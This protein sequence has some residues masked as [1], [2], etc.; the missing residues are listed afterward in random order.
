MSYPR[1]KRPRNLLA[2]MILN[3]LAGS[4]AGA[5]A[6][7]L[8]YV[9]AEIIRLGPLSDAGDRLMFFL[10]VI[11]IAL[12]Y[13][14]PVVLVLVFAGEYIARRVA[15]IPSKGIGFVLLLGVSG[16]GLALLANLFMI[17][18]LSFDLNEGLIRNT[19]VAASVGGTVAGVIVAIRIGG[20]K[21]D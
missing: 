6:T 17:W 13:S 2:Q 18:S 7:S 1:Q 16:F 20:K 19:M 9:I 10:L 14:V 15:V 8:V 5:A 4:I 11:M 3:L 21:D 12:I